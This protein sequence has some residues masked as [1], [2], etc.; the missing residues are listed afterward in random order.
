MLDWGW[1]EKKKEIWED[2]NFWFLKLL[3]RFDTS[4]VTTSGFMK[5][6]LSK[7]MKEG[8]QK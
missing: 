6:Y 3:F 7:I 5:T 1:K 4:N 8:R 2:K